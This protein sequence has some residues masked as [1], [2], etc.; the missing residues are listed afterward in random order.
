[1]KHNADK[2]IVVQCSS[3]RGVRHIAFHYHYDST[4]TLSTGDAKLLASIRALKYKLQ[5]WRVIAR[6]ERAR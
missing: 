4:S 5:G 1:M 2:M 3:P 6:V